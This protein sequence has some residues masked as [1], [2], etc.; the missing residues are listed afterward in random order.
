MVMTELGMN[1][2]GLSATL[3]EASLDKSDAAGISHQPLDST[4]ILLWLKVM[5]I[6]AI[7]FPPPIGCLC[8]A[9]HFCCQLSSPFSSCLYFGHLSLTSNT[10]SRQSNQCRTDDC[11]Y[12]RRDGAKQNEMRVDYMRWGLMRQ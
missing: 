8:Y 4:V 2:Q 3:L 10:G 6:C 11:N 7:F 5:K 12:T 1:K 9:I